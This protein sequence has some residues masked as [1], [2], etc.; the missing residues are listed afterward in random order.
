MPGAFCCCPSTINVKLKTL[1]RALATFA[2]LDSTHL[3]S[4]TIRVFLQ[5]AQDGPCTYKHLE[6][7]LSLSNSAISRTVLK[8]GSTD[9]KGK[10]GF[11]LIDTWPD[12]KE[13]RRY[14]VQLNEHGCKLAGA[15]QAL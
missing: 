9:A 14:L 15:L 8:L 7:S 5:I 4:H 10:A 1:Q 11:N 6:N 13:G 3:Y 2:L 12:P